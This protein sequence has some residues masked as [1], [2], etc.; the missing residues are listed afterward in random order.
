MKLILFDTS[1]VLHRSFHAYNL[2][3]TRHGAEIPTGHIFGALRAYRSITNRFP[4]V[5]I[6]LC[7]DSYPVH[8]MLLLSDYKEGRGDRK[9]D[10]SKAFLHLSLLLSRKRDCYVTG[11]PDHEAD[12]VIA[13][14]TLRGDR[15]P[16]LIFSGDDDMLQLVEDGV[17]VARK[18]S[19][20]GKLEI[21]SEVYCDIR[22]GVRPGVL[23]FYKVIVGESDNIRGI[24]GFPRKLAASLVAEYPS[25]GEIRG[26]RQAVFTK[27]GTTPAKLSYL[28]KLFSRLSNMEL[29]YKGLVHLPSI[30][31][32][33]DVPS[34]MKP[35]DELLEDLIGYYGLGQPV[36]EFL[37]REQ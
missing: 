1:W 7:K 5:P 33:M 24:V 18:F 15:K 6:Y 27:Y 35:E 31:D 12:D 9:F 21:L 2:S 36:S 30:V 22:Y 29:L 17:H 25:P 26:H 23:A 28:V 20:S 16:V 32:K 11:H 37:R 4:G 34:V 8:K 14:W 19:S 10:L 13:Y 3:V